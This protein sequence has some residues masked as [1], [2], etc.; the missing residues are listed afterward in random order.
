MTEMHIETNYIPRSRLIQNSEIQLKTAILTE[1][2]NGLIIQLID[3]ELAFLPNYFIKI[4]N[5]IYKIIT[6]FRNSVNTLLITKRV[7]ITK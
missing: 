3:D 1:R 7:V 6:T 2:K 5:H 4:N